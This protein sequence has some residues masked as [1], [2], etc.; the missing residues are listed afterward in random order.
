M[1]FGPRGARPQSGRRL[2]GYFLRHHSPSCPFTAGAPLGAPAEGC[3]AQGPPGGVHPRQPSEGR[4]GG[5]RS[6]SAWRGRWRPCSSRRVL[7][8]SHGLCG[9]WAQ[10][11]TSGTLR[12]GAASWVYLLVSCLCVWRPVTAR[13]SCDCCNR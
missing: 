8:A 13:A 9:K 4:G 12:S 10:A 7:S 5:A 11:Q 2:G 3:R 1:D 6:A